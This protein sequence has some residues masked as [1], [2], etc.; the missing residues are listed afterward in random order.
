MNVKYDERNQTRQRQFSLAEV[1]F[2]LVYVVGRKVM[3]AN[4]MSRMDTTE[5]VLLI[6][7]EGKKWKRLRN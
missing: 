2:F 4:A 5:N 1:S 3:D 7:K 6:L